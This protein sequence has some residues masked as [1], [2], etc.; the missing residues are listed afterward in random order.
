MPSGPFAHVCLLVHDLDKAVEDWTKILAVL[1]PKQLEK[2]LVRYDYFEGGEDRMRW[3]T[4]VNP[5]STSGLFPNGDNKYVGA[6]L[7]YL[8]VYQD[9]KDLKRAQVLANF[10]RWAMRDGQEVAAS[11]DSQAR[12][13][14]DAQLAF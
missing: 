14:S 3:A 2:R 7:T 8:L 11:L 1:D 4:F 10:I 5:G 6:G 12:L 13:L 9:S